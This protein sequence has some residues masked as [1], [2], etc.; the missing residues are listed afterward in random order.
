MLINL[1]ALCLEIKGEGAEVCSSPTL[2]GRMAANS[3]TKSRIITR[4]VQFEF[5][6]PDAQEVYLVGK[7]NNWNVGETPM[8]KDK[9]G[10]WKRT[11]SLE[12]GIYEYRFFVDGNRENDPS[13]SS[14]VPN[15]FGTKN[16]VRSV[17]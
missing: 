1:K 4:E 11:L 16:C 5:P 9:N 13:C 12:A 7:F 6:A 15:E 17:V 2:E 3:K 14:C 8:K 10:V